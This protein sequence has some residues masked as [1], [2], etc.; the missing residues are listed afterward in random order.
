MRTIAT[1][2]IVLSLVEGLGAAE[3]PLVEKY[4]H[5]GQ[6]AKGEQV[7]EAALAVNPKN[8][9]ARFGLGVLQVVR[10]VERL[11]QSLHE[12]G[13][14]SENT[15]LPFVRLP[16]PSNPDASPITYTDFR[17][18]LQGF[19]SDL[20][21]AEATLASVTDDRVLLPLRMANIHLDLDGDGKPNDKLIDRPINVIN[22]ITGFQRVLAE[23]RW[24][25]FRPPSPPA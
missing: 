20:A 10:G 21:T 24:I 16:V 15:H 4:L 14:R 7:L 19:H 6:L 5:S 3:P 25:D 9:Q 13:C 8:D 23:V 11:G 18:I 17:R 12:Y 1:M 22:K 2:I